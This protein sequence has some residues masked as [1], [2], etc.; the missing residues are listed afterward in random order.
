[1]T[2]YK[3][4]HDLRVKYAQRL[5][6]APP[7]PQ[8]LVTTT[9][10]DPCWPDFYPGDNNGYLNLYSLA[11]AGDPWQG[12]ILKVNQGLNPNFASTA[13]G[14]LQQ[15]W[16]VARSTWG[17]R[18][19]LTGFRGGYSYVMI[20]EDGRKQGDYYC[21][22]IDQCGGWGDGDFW[23]ILDVESAGQPANA[24]NQQIID[25]VSSMA[26]R[27][28]QR[29]GRMI[30]RYSG[31]YIRDRQIRNAMGC[32]L[33]WVADW[34]KTLNSHTYLDQGYTLTPTPGSFG[35]CIAWQGVGDGHGSWTGYPT[36]APVGKGGAQVPC[37]VSAGIVL[38]GA[39]P[40][41][42]SSW[43]SSHLGGQLTA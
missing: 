43:I 27:I 26:E 5:L 36:T 2:Q 6:S 12:V 10:L 25:T 13:S 7:Q 34:E 42:V 40:V 31:S 14:W 24:T 3:L 41:K 4:G 9:N 17:G 19:G 11:N 33:L 15:Y 38:G 1:M 28:T 37:D 21:D 23:P 29:T 32:K 8:S 22:L 16:A 39:D 20:G 30:M 35:L 18:Y